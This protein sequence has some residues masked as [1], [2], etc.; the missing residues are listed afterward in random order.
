MKDFVSNRRVSILAWASSL[1]ILWALFVVPSGQ[2]WA[3]LVWFGALAFLFVS[4]VVLV[5]GAA[6][7]PVLA[8]AIHA[9]DNQGT[10]RKS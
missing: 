1:S 9:V 8:P 5:L 7:A 10:G 6:T 2:P 3:G 4:S